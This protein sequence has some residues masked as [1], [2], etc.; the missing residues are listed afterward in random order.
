MSLIYA[1]IFYYTFFDITKSKPPLRHT[2]QLYLLLLLFIFIYLLKLNSSFSSYVYLPLPLP[3]FIFP[4][5][6][7]P[8]ST[9]LRHDSQTPLFHLNT[10]TDL[11]VMTT[12]ELP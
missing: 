11:E 5:M 9:Y 2:F 12:S 4:E 10:N 7:S 3:M 8:I 1:K 6:C